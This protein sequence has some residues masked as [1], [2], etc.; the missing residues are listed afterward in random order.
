M[1][2]LII[3]LIS[4]NLFF[5]NS[6]VYSFWIN[7]GESWFYSSIDNSVNELESQIYSIEIVWENW[8]KDG[9]NKIAW[10]KCLKNNL[11]WKQIK[12][13]VI[14]WNL[15]I[16]TNNIDSSCLE[17]WNIS[18][19]LINTYIKAITEFYNKNKQ[20]SEKKVQQ[21]YW[22]SNM[23]L[24]SDWIE[25]N[26][27][28]DLI[29]DLQNIDSIIFSE[30]STQYEWVED[31]DLWS[32]IE[33]L[34]NEK[35]KINSVPL[36]P[37]SEINTN[38]TKQ[39]NSSKI[40]ISSN[41]TVQTTNLDNN[42]NICSIDNTISWLKE[43]SINFLLN[44]LDNINLEEVKNNESII[45]SGKTNTNN[46]IENLY[47]EENSY[48][49]ITDN[50]EFPCNWFFCID[51]N[52]ITYQHNLLWW[53]FEDI[54]IEYLINRSN[55]HLK[56]F[57]NTSLVQANM[58]TSNFE[59]WLKDLNLPDI[60]HMWFQITQKPVPILNIE[61]KNKKDEWIFALDS[62]LKS[63]Y[64]SYWLDYK[65]RNDLS[66]FSK[67]VNEKQV[68]QNN[69][70]WTNQW[71]LNQIKEIS[72][73]LEEKEEKNNLFTKIVQEQTRYDIMSDFEIQFKEL[74]IFNKSINNYV[75]NLDSV[76]SNM[77]KIP[78]W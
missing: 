68:V 76:I 77:L 52:F 7:F 15:T 24:Y 64:E 41:S 39:N 35:N 29:K 37:I 8:T 20:I 27:P 3:T 23:W 11:S 6:F 55:D 18:Q 25:K 14:N 30:E 65:R 78:N 2:K 34:L 9:I 44:N 71:L 50:S 57:T 5:I 67:I 10:T 66:L 17:D 56:K 12:S 22:I 61:P 69:Q 51:I 75:N 21:I 28:F 46:W 26:A 40:N 47:P 73:Y 72:I 60:F 62:Q 31:Y 42:S 48:S 43:N 54:T 53:W 16:I 1:R 59:L 70:L 58:T 38:Q 63:Y 36:N 33:K 4:L 74:E 19:N 32:N 13:L 45:E 49:K